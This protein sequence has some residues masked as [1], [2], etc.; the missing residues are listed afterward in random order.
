MGSHYCL[1]LK[2]S[3]Y[4]IHYSRQTSTSTFKS[5]L[6]TLQLIITG[7]NWRHVCIL[8]LKVASSYKRWVTNLSQNIN[9]PQTVCLIPHTHIDTHTYTHTFLLTHGP[10]ALWGE[11]SCVVFTFLR[12]QSHLDPRTPTGPGGRPSTSTSTCTGVRRL[13]GARDSSR[14]PRL[15]VARG[16]VRDS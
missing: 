12:H 10:A 8:H 6:Q 1:P 14:A 2:P 13:H 9:N 15:R 11:L 7:D 5:L 16:R 4:T 3:Y